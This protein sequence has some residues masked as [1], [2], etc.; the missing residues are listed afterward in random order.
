MTRTIITWIWTKKMMG[1]KIYFWMIFR[2]IRNYLVSFFVGQQIFHSYPGLNFLCKFWDDWSR[3]V[4]HASFSARITNRKLLKA[5]LAADLNEQTFWIFSSLVKVCDALGGRTLPGAITDLSSLT[6][7]TPCTHVDTDVCLTFHKDWPVK[8]WN[9]IG[10]LPKA[11]YIL[12]SKK[13]AK[14]LE[15]YHFLWN[16]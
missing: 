12:H 6:H 5:K 8:T 9:V 4:C 2:M 3:W 14:Y 10:I 15:Y 13:N 11:L 16:C 1:M 7:I